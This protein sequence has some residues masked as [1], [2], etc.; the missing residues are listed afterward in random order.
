MWQCLKIESDELLREKKKSDNNIEWLE[1][2]S[3]S[4]PRDNFFIHH[5][6][7]QMEP[8]KYKGENWLTI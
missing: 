6:Q 8:T 5:A 3:L 2:L 7:I 1:K 4:L